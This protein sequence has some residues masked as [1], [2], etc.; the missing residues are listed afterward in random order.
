MAYAA[1][2]AR[3]R[4]PRIAASSRALGTGLH[5]AVVAL[6]ACGKATPRREKPRPV[7]V[8]R[9]GGGADAASAAF[10][11]EI[12]AREESPLSFRVGG[13]HR[14]APGRCRR[15]TC[16]RGDLLA[17]LDPGRPARAGRAAQ[18]QLA[19]AE[20]ELAP[21][22]R[23]PGALRQ[24]RPASSW[25]AVRRSMRRTPRHAAAAGPGQCRARQLDVARNQAA[26]TQLRAPRDGVI[27]SAQR[28]SRAGGRRRPGRSSRSPPTAA[29]KSRSRCRNRASAISAVGQ[30]V[31]VEL[32]S[33]ARPAPAGHASAR[34][35]P[36]AD[37]QARTYAAR[38][39]LD[40]D[41]AKARRTRPERARV[42]A[43]ATARDGGAER[44]AVGAAA[45]RQRRDRGVGGRSG[46]AQRCSCTPVQLGAVRRDTRAGAVGPRR[47]TTGSSPPAATCCAKARRSRRWIATTA[48]SRRAT[49]SPAKRSAEPCRRFNLSEW[50]LRNR[51]L[52]VYAM[53]VL[54]LI[55]VWSLPQPGPVARIRRSP[56]R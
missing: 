48:R 6:A 21:R 28:R 50:A 42:R 47:R 40:G 35:P 55:G 24:A 54:A 20:A 51:S 38:V 53:L 30:P 36:A 14:A 44:A 56:S 46:D 1:Q 11:G 49:A 12:R 19:A 10:A 39:A 43:A 4:R 2:D 45:R 34:S 32:W 27:A 31:L 9:P 16:V 26:Y 41:A 13:K 15:R 7:L 3:H 5:A 25:S 17:V 29:A 52:V 8:V 23:R 22:Q 33:A 37:P 18:A